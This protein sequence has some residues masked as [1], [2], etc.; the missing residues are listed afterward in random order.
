MGLDARAQAGI[1]QGNRRLKQL[2]I[3]EPDYRYKKLI[4]VFSQVQF[5][6]E[7]GDLALERGDP[8]F[9]FSNSAGLGLFVI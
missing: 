3:D 9:V 2:L 4:V 6:G 5:H 8:E 7:L 1:L